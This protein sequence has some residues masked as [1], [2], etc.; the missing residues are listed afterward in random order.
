[1]TNTEN[2]W[3]KM[4]K[5][6]LRRV[7]SKIGYDF[8]WV[9]DEI[10]RYCLKISFNKQ[11]QQKKN[12]PSL[13][14]VDVIVISGSSKSFDLYLVLLVGENWK[15]F[16]TLC[17]DL[18]NNAFKF[19]EEEIFKHTILRLFKW[20]KFLSSNNEPT[21]D[22][23]IQMG[24]IGELYF[25]LNYILPNYA[26]EEAMSFWVGPEMDKQDFHLSKFAVEVKSFILSKG[27]IVSISSSSQLDNTM[28]P[29]YLFS[30]GLTKLENGNISLPILINEIKKKIGSNE[31]YQEIFDEKLAKYGFIDGITKEPFYSYDESFV[32]SYLVSDDFPKIISRDISNEI[33]DLNYRIDLSKC[34]RFIFDL[35]KLLI[36]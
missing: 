27:K 23:K 20:Q 32:E 31:L 25:L 33:I 3:I 30:I 15:M 35:S 19:K 24:L 34:S 22:E 5:S 6:S 1:M 9:I 13:K 17:D 28:K 2:P 26:I 36:N 12:L 21:L 7:D 18:L 14:G 29:L 4:E 11:F 10:G 8:F 16:K